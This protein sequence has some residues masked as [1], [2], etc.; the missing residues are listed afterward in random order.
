V[1]HVALVA[2]GCAGKRSVSSGVNNEVGTRD[3]NPAAGAH[4]FLLDRSN[5]AGAIRWP[6]GH[7]VVPDDGAA[8]A[9]QAERIV[10][11]SI[12]PTIPRATS[13]QF[14]REH[15]RLVPLARI[16][17]RNL[18]D[19]GLFARQASPGNFWLA[20]WSQLARIRFEPHEVEVPGPTAPARLPQS[21]RD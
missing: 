11:A 6:V 8:R 20:D 18:I 7:V 15:K 4:D 3:M 12:M 14:T 21:S 2:P 10:D 13:R 17:M 1:V 9:E 5:D 19:A 16:F